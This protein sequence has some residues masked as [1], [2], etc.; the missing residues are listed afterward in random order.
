V[1][2]ADAVGRTSKSREKPFKISD[3]GGLYL[4]VETNGS[5]LA[6]CLPF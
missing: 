5:K 3:R 1:P 2:I 6:S 4:L